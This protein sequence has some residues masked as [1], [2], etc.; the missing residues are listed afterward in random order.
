MAF[1]KK[2]GKSD[3]EYQESCLKTRRRK[4]IGI[5][6]QGRPGLVLGTVP[7]N[8]VVAESELSLENLESENSACAISA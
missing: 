4:G 3:S 8:K 7:M 5:H 2:K 1:C 6:K